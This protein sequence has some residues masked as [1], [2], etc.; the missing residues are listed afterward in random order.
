MSDGQIERNLTER[1]HIEYNLIE[2]ILIDWAGVG[3]K[4]VNF[5]I[6]EIIE[7]LIFDVFGKHSVSISSLLSE[8]RG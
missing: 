6:F 2:L 7:R 8:H 5:E 3:S 1:N 4:C